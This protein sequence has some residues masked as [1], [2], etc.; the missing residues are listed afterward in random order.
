MNDRPEKEI[1]PI[2][3]GE[4]S[5]KKSET[6]DERLIQ[7]AN[8]LIVKNWNGYSATFRLKELVEEFL[9]ICHKKSTDANRAKVY[10]EHCLD[11]ENT[12]RKAGWKVDYDQPGYNESYDAFFEFT[13]KK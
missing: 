12:F 2:K 13:K 3:P 1:K 4:V 9:R 5:D 10:K 11:I 7:A 8:N 6:V